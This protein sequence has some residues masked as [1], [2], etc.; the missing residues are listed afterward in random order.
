[1]NLPFIETLMARLQPGQTVRLWKPRAESLGGVF[2]LR[3]HH[4]FLKG[5]TLVIP[6]V[7]VGLDALPAYREP[8]W[9]EGFVFFVG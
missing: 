7:R 5:H 1:M 3:E 6:R 8:G 9:F 4:L 2:R